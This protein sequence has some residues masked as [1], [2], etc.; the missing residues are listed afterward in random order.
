MKRY[1]KKND[2]DISMNTVDSIATFQVSNLGPMRDQQSS[3]SE[4]TSKDEQETIKSQR[5]ILK[6]TKIRNIPKNL[7][8]AEIFKVRLEERDPMD[9]FFKDLLVYGTIGD[10]ADQAI[11]ITMRVIE[12]SDIE[13]EDS[14][15]PAIDKDPE[16]KTQVQWTSNRD[17]SLSF[18]EALLQRVDNINATT[19]DTKRLAKK[20]GMPSDRC[21]QLLRPFYERSSD[22]YKLRAILL[23]EAAEFDRENTPRFLHAYDTKSNQYLHD[24]TVLGVFLTNFANI[25]V[26]LPNED[27]KRSKFKKSPILSVHQGLIS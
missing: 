4:E 11:Y 25:A 3:D 17:Q 23:Q 2:D 21:F 7:A 27:L 9:Y 18:A 8:G 13:K 1:K 14:K 20:C 26:P 15:P 19:A 24:D 22:A 12:G 10:L 16:R 5:P 6:Q